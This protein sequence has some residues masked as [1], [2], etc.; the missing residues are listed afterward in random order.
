MKHSISEIDKGII[1]IEERIIVIIFILLVKIKVNEIEER[2][3][4][5]IAKPNELVESTIFILNFF[6]SSSEIKIK[7]K[8]SIIE[9]TKYRININKFTSIHFKN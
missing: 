8:V 7:K 1:Q 5:N 9:M 6:N 3:S 4:P 2:I